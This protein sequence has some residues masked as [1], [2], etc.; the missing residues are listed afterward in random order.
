MGTE[1]YLEALHQLQPALLICV[2]GLAH[3]RGG[4]SSWSCASSAATYPSH[5]LPGNGCGM[6]MAWISC[7][8]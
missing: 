3:Q 2:L 4:L 7:R 8:Q 6:A 5:R 1:V